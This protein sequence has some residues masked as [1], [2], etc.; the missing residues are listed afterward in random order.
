MSTSA[1]T[2]LRFRLLGPLEVLRG[3][4]P[5]PLGGERQ[6]GLL[7]LLLLHA[8]E[9]V[10]TEY[11]A[12][13]MFGADASEA[14]IRTV[15]VAVSRLRRLLD[16]E[17]LVTRPGGYLVHT[18]AEQLDVAEFE[19]LVA[20][21]RDALDAGEASAAAVAFR[22]A[23]ALFRG[24][25]LA[26]LALLDFLQPEVRR[27]EQLR[28]STVMDRI[29][30]DLALG[31]AA[32]VVP[33]LEALVR[34]NV[35]QERLRGQL[36]LALYRSGRQ[37]DALEVYRQTRELLAEEVGLEPSR[38]L[39]A[40]ERRILQHDPALELPPGHRRAERPPGLP[41]YEPRESALGRRH[42]RRLATV[43]AGTALAA[44]AATLIIFATDSHARTR[45]TAPTPLGHHLRAAISSPLPSCCAFGFGGVWVVGHHD[46]TVEKLDPT[47][48][49]VVARY[50][51]A[52]FQA[53]APLMAAGSLWVPAAGEP[54]FIRFDPVRRR[55]IATFPVEA[56]ELAWGYNSIWATTRDH[57]LVR[58]D[59][60]RNRIAK[61]LQLLPGYNDFNDG[62]AI[63]YG[64]IWVTATDTATLLR[65]DP[66][67]MTVV[68]RITGF[69]DDES[70]MPITT[71]DGSVWIY[72]ITAGQGIVYRIDPFTNQI[73]ARIPVGH[74]NVAWPNGYILDAGGYVWTCDAGST[75][76]AI[77]PQEN[78]VVGWYRVPESCQ[79]IAYGDGSIW[80][81]LYDHSLVYRIDPKP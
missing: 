58:I 62:I 66:K 49:K 22:D 64:S 4:E 81:A 10:T 21:G 80:T 35:Y 48:R 27:L 57:H 12:E 71:G 5:L 60:R 47:T 7:A 69:G 17:T 24:P 63:G 25:P 2:G 70:W 67:T 20:E 65:I 36:M 53:E 18:D 44:A 29:D 38:S 19:A 30:A 15:R 28:L 52:G 72:R 56:S 13:Q 9:L 76:S 31:R 32:E 26:D 33:D 54:K 3:D 43:I 23:L 6:R 74:P 77:D 11:L 46:M 1:T 79:E 61:R 34:A 78:R 51:V 42:R 55:V 41:G 8:N 68:G 75:M 59:L 39:Q 50:P 45:L 73:V 40:L 37:T 16:E 14:S